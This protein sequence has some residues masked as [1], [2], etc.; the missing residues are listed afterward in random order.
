M[1]KTGFEELKKS[2]KNLTI[3]RLIHLFFTFHWK[4]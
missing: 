3:N 2:I 1:G 4:V